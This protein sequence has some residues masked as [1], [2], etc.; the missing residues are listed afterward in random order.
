VITIA[1]DFTVEGSGEIPATLVN[2]GLIRAFPSANGDGR[3]RLF[4]GTKTNNALMVAD[5]GGELLLDSASVN[6]GSNGLLLADGGLVTFNG[7]VSLAGGTLAD[8]NGGTI[9]RVGNGTLSLSNL[10]LDGVLNCN[11][12]STTAYGSTGLVNNG[13]IRLNADGSTADAILRFDANTVVTGNG[14]IEMLRPGNDARINNNGTTITFGPGQTVR[15]GGAING[16]F[17]M[18]GRVEPGLPIGR[19]SGTGTVS[20]ADTTVIE[21]ETDGPGSGDGFTYSSGT[22]N[23]DGVVD[24]R[25]AGYVPAV[26]DEFNLITAST[27]NGVFDDVFVSGGVLPTSIA[28]RLVYTP[29]TVNVTFVCIADIAEPFGLLDLA[30][31]TAF[32]DAF[33]NQ[34][35]LADLAEPIGLFDLADLNAFVL[36]FLG[37][38]E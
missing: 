3:L 30:D 22:F 21:A 29:T 2:N 9:T 18:Q 4:A 19:I 11:G 34:E 38:C 28:V 17:T 24:V 23:L 7:N 25:L 33:L 32:V 5:P 16:V 36:G 35:P 15:G 14:T 8:S 37:N 27:I 12:G 20:F 6:Q 31:V 26:N 13:A 1:S 10:T